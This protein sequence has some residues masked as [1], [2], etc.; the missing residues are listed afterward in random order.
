MKLICFLSL[1]SLSLTLTASAQKKIDGFRLVDNID[2]KQID[3]L[4]NNKLLTAYYYADSIKKP[5]LFP[6]KTVSGITVTR[7][8]PITPREGE[9][10]DHP[11]HAGMWLNYESVN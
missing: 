7:G 9:P 6:I 4:F 8:F 10:V 11:H 5:I 3:V 2:A 1:V